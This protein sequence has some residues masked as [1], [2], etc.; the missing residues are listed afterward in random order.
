[1]FKQKSKYIRTLIKQG[2]KVRLSKD[3]SRSITIYG[4]RTVKERLQ[5]EIVEV[6]HKDDSSIMIEDPKLGG[7]WT[8]VNEEIEDIFDK[9]GNS[10]IEK[11]NLPEAE[12]FNPENLIL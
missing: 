8:I 9:N 4:G 6:R 7:Y 3:L 1:M 5:G 2:M 10:I 12:I 11:P